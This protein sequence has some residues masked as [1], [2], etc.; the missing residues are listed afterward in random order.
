VTSL[1]VEDVD[2]DIQ[3]GAV[4]HHVQGHVTCVL[5]V[6]RRGATYI[7]A[8]NGLRIAEWRDRQ[9]TCVVAAGGLHVA[10]HAI[11]VMHAVGVGVLT[12]APFIPSRFRNDAAWVTELTIIIVVVGV[13]VASGAHGRTQ[14]RLVRRT[15]LR[16][17]VHGVSE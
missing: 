10:I 3:G 12:A 7:V 1:V 5:Q 14:L 16:I 6:Q 17:G 15:H 4:L 2:F 8:A 13:L 11:G 9:R